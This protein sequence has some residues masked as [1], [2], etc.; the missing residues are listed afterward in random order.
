LVDGL[1]TNA[2]AFLVLFGLATLGCIFIA[3]VAWHLLRHLKR[4]A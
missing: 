3:A 4:H 2:V 1:L